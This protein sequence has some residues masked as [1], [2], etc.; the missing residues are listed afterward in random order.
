MI[1]ASEIVDAISA[2]DAA[3]ELISDTSGNTENRAYVRILLTRS[4]ID[5][6]YALKDVKIPVMATP[7]PDLE[8]SS[9]VVNL[10]VLGETQEVAA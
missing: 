6:R 5:L 2:I 7:E 10:S 9:M 4:R 8:F 3:L 1:N